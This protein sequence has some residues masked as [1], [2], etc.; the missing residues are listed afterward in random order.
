M[1]WRRF[2]HDFFADTNTNSDVA[3][4]H[5]HSGPDSYSNPFTIANSERLAHSDANSPDLVAAH[6]LT[7]GP[8]RAG[9]ATAGCISVST[10][11]L[12]PRQRCSG[13]FSG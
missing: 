3:Y 13:K 10:N 5:S 1:R 6:Q 2:Q 11:H 4:A 9:T 7:A 8:A 12:Q